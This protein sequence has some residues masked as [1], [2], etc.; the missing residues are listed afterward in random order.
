LAYHDE[1]NSG[2]SNEDTDLPEGFWDD[3][4]KPTYWRVLVAPTRPKEVSKGGIVLALAN[5]E[6]QDILNF[7]GKVV[8]LGPM[9]GKHERLG[10][11]GKA[12][13]PDFPKV[14]DYVAFGRFAGAKILHR[15]VRI[16]ILND[17]EILA[18]VPNPETLQTSK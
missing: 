1:G 12:P 7:I 18:V 11:D 6:A 5:Q 15:G 14:G 8:A 16:L 13:G 3:L 10:G 9:A 4:P 2:W 17:D